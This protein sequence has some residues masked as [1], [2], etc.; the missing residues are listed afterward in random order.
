MHNNYNILN[1]KKIHHMTNF[2]I[3]ILENLNKIITITIQKKINKALI[4]QVINK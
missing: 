2:K 4:F 1:Y 3:K